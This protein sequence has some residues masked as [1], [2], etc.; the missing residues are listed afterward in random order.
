M[1]DQQSTNEQL[2][3][4]N[5]AAEEI[6]NEAG[7]SDVSSEEQVAPAAELLEEVQEDKEGES[8]SNEGAEPIEPD[9]DSTSEG[10]TFEAAEPSVATADPLSPGVQDASTA[11]PVAEVVSEPIPVAAPVVEIQPAVDQSEGSS[12]NQQYLNNIRENGTLIQKQALDA[13]DQFCT[14][15][16]PRAPISATQ[17]M[18]AQRDL[19]DFIT[20]LLRKD[21]EDFRKGWATMLVYFA[22]HHGDRP[23]AKDYTPL[24]EYSTSRHLDSWK[25]EERANAYNNL[26]TLL[27]VTR[28]SETRKQDVKRVRLDAIAPTFLNAR[29]MDNLQRFYA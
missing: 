26:L 19:L 5:D 29:C 6:Q 2:Q 3:G 25:D 21:Y 23:T 24:S 14:R 13:L 11:A 20:V 8:D 12:E 17:A 28:N 7:V 1:S 9:A 16:R 15:M 18:E 22:E 10:P 4:E 27:R